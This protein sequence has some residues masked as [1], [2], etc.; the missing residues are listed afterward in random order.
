[1]G[2]AYDRHCRISV[3]GCDLFL[4]IAGSQYVGLACVR[5]CWISV[6]GRGL[7]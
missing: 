5:H 6:C 1:M 2:V 4:G 7:C 3:C